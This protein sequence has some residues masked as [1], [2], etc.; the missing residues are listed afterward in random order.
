MTTPNELEAIR[1]RRERQIEAREWLNQ[2][3]AD[4]NYHPT[5]QEAANHFMS[6]EVKWS[7]EHIDTLLAHIER[8]E[9]MYTSKEPGTQ[10]AMLDAYHKIAEGLP[11]YNPVDSS[12]TGVDVIREHIER[13]QAIEAAAADVLVAADYY[14]AVE[15]SK[16]MN[17]LREAVGRDG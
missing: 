5:G 3:E 15:T 10:G 4:A 17:A 8:L 11:G 13:L 7:G 16:A 14:D 12:K 2:V 9:F 6:A 1:Q